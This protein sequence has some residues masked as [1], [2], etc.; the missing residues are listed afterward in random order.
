MEVEGVKNLIDSKPSGESAARYVHKLTSLSA[1]ETLAAHLT[2]GIFNH[3]LEVLQ[4]F[5]SLC[6]GFT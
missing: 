3:R 4:H 5:V 6:A 1:P 2:P